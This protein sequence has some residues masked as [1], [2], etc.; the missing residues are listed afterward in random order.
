MAQ[1]R[2]SRNLHLHTDVRHLC[3]TTCGI[4]VNY[5]SVGSGAG[6][7]QLLAQTVDFGATDSPM[8]DADMAK[9]T[10]GPIVHIPG[11]LG[12]VAI[13]YNQP[14]FMR[15]KRL[16]LK[17]VPSRTSSLARSPSGTIQPLRLTIPA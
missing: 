15:A 3:Q 8:T 10:N 14:A 6:I 11:T 2:H 5:Q 16:Q 4:R 1:A 13:S 7:S 12:G 9:S 17:G